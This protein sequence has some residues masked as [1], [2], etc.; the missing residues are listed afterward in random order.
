[1]KKKLQINILW[2]WVK[3]TDIVGVTSGFPRHH[4]E[5]SVCRKSCSRSLRSVVF[6]SSS[7]FWSLSKRSL[8]AKYRRV[9]EQIKFCLYS[10]PKA[11]LLIYPFHASLWHYAAINLDYIYIFVFAVQNIIRPLEDYLRSSNTT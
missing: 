11:L 5:V 6:M 4:L 1:M 2:Q 10:H 9:P 7:E 3:M 8:K